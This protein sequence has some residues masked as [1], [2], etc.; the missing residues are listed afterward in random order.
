MLYHYPYPDGSAP[1]QAMGAYL[2]ACARLAGALVRLV[3]PEVSVD[4]V[5][6]QGRFP[7]RIVR[8]CDAGEAMALLLAA[9]HQCLFK[10]ALW[11]RSSRSP[12]WRMFSWPSRSFESNVFGS[13]RETPPSAGNIMYFVY[14]TAALAPK[15]LAPLLVS[16]PPD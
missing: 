2:R 7:L 15:P 14:S 1:R 5:L 9:V 8:S 4:G 10:S 6:I 3:D 12:R 13:A 11:S 16:A